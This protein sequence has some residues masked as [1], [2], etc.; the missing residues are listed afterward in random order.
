MGGNPMALLKDLGERFEG[1]GWLGVG[2]GAVVL[3]PVVAPALVRGM[4]PALK[5]AIKGYFMLS[6]R[7][8]HQLAQTGEQFQ[9]LVAEGKAEYDLRGSEAEMAS[10]EPGDNGDHADIEGGEAPPRAHRRHRA[11]RPA[12]HPESEAA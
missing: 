3:A 10:L 5:G 4:R 9:D 6:D 7:L 11:A 1:K 8:R 2:I 12:D